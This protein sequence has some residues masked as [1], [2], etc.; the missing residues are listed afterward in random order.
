MSI[1]NLG[2][3]YF[4]GEAQDLE[5]M[6]G[7]LIDNPCKWTHDQV[8]IHATRDKHNQRIHLFVEDNGPGIPDSQLAIV[9]Q[10]G[11]KSYGLFQDHGLGLRA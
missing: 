7:N 3:N 1:Q 10:R 5:E 9:L 2:N 11:R 6:L 8:W 4:C